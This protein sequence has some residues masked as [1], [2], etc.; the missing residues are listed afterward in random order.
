[1]LVRG[2]KALSFLLGTIFIVSAELVDESTSLREL[3]ISV[4]EK[5][6]KSGYKMKNQRLAGLCS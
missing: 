1:M 5:D 6:S 2:R 4:D 3:H